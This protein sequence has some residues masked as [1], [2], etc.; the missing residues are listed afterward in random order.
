MTRAAFTDS[1]PETASD[2]P[3][4]NN[5]RTLRPNTSHTTRN[6]VRLTN[7]RPL[8]DSRGTGTR[9]LRKCLV[10]TNRYGRGKRC[11]ATHGC[12]MP[13]TVVAAGD[14][15]ACAL[16]AAQVASAALHGH[17]AGNTKWT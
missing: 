1:R 4:K 11:T 2:W 7:N 15:N 16:P 8:H 3:S 12:R 6:V 13:A 5:R 9:V 17:Y 14:A 10:A